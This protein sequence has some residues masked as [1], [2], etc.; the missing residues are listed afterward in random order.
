MKS[1]SVNKGASDI[2]AYKVG[3]ITHTVAGVHENAEQR[4][5]I[6]GICAT[7]YENIPCLAARLGIAPR[8]VQ[9]WMKQ[10]RIPF[11]RIGRLTRFN[12][13]AVDAALGAYSVASRSK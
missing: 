6:K 11:L 7:A 4:E 10:G 5:R 2:A 8:T 12:P 1:Q 13:Q 3:N 9:A